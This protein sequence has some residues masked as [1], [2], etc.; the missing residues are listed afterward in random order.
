MESLY[1]IGVDFGT[2][3][4]RA[5]LVNARTGEVCGTGVASYQRWAKGLYCVP[6]E[7]Q[8]RQHPLDY[9]E[10]L[11]RCILDCLAGAEQ[12]VCDQR[13]IHFVSSCPDLDHRSI[14]RATSRFALPNCSFPG[15]PQ[16]PFLINAITSPKTILR[17]T[18]RHNNSNN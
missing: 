14:N 7:H 8:F 15:T 16:D 4:S 11:E 12:E 10:S 2:D 5:L 9:T 13:H 17:N 6:S 1:V 3:S 18:L